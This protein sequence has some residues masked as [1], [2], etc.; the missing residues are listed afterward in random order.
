MR[1][2][3]L[4]LVKVRETKQESFDYSVVIQTYRL[5]IF[6]SRWHGPFLL[7]FIL[8][9]SWTIW[10]SLKLFVFAVCFTRYVQGYSFSISCLISTRISNYLIKHYIKGYIQLCYYMII[11]FLNF[12]IA[13]SFLQNTLLTNESVGV[14]IWNW[15]NKK[16][17]I[18]FE[19]SL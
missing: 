3:F 18:M 17:I 9:A 2:L 4:G 1:F 15:Y 16:N 11:V 14:Y 12:I 5:I 13:L 19:K 10:K 8:W 7:F 6:G